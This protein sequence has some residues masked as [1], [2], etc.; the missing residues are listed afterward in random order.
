MSQIVPTSWFPVAK[1]GHGY[2]H[3]E[4]RYRVQ[5]FKP[6][7]NGSAQVIEESMPG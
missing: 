3:P 7:A 1:I 2:G 4:T 6:V 5:G